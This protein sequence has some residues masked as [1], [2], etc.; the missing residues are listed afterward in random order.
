M[1]SAI[2]DSSG[3]VS[4]GHER[5]DRGQSRVG[6]R[7]AERRRRP[8][9]AAGSRSAAAARV[10][11][12]SRRAR[13]APSSRAVAPL[14][15]TAAG[16]RRWRTR[17]AA[18]APR[19]RTAPRCPADAARERLLERQQADAPLVRELRR[20]ALLQVR[21]DRP[22]DP[23]PPAPPLTPGFSRPSRCTLRTPSTTSPRSNADRQIDVGAAPHEALRHHAD[24]R[25]DC[26]VEPE[27]AAEDARIAAELPLPEPVAQHDDR[28][29]ASAAHRRRSACGRGA[30]ARPSRRTC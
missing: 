9:P 2:S 13:R 4:G 6:E 20:L 3:I 8:A 19:R 1:L 14:P 5:E 26:V 10:A 30:A 29:G 11:S 12:G 16:S 25:A 22:R 21:D 15:S 17:S 18:A 28:L 7:A 23:P 24:D 27:L